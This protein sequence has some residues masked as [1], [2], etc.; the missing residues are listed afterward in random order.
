MRE[1]EEEGRAWWRGGEGK[2]K[3][4]R[5]DKD[6]RDARRKRAMMRKPLPSRRSLKPRGITSGSTGRH[7]TCVTNVWKEDE[8]NGWKATS[9]PRLQGSQ[10]IPLASRDGGNHQCHAAF[11]LNTSSPLR[12][13]FPCSDDIC[14]LVTFAMMRSST[15]FIHRRRHESI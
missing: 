8:G 14:F 9:R 12:H 4:G 1:R 6:L 3:G 10:I 7:Q 13:A 5:G 11:P 2:V 15:A